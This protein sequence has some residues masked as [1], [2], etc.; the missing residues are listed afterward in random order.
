MDKNRAQ[1]IMRAPTKIEVV[2]QGEPVWIEGV[3][4]TSANITIMGTSRTADVPLE[5]LQETGKYEY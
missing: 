2:Y 3:D 1:E 4:E 5:E